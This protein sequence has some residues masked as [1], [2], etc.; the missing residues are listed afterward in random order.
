VAWLL[1]SL[2]YLVLH[3]LVY[4]VVLR[5]RDAFRSERGVFM[6]HAASAVVVTLAVLIGAAQASWM[7]GL[8]IETLATVVAVVCLHGIYSMTFLEV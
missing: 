4:L 7:D 8:A 1:G 3:A 6:Y 2:A 5:T